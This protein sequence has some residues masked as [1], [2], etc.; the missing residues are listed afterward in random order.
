MK[1]FDLLN[2][3]CPAGAAALVV[4]FF[5]KLPPAVLIFSAAALLVAAT[6]LNAARRARMD[7]LHRRCDEL[8]N[9]LEQQ[10]D[11]HEQAISQLKSEQETARSAFFSEISHSLRM[12]ISVIQGYA[13]LMQSGAVDQVRV[14]EYL[15]R[16][17]HHTHRM[18]DVL[19]TKLSP[20]LEDGSVSPNQGQVDLVLLV[21]NQIKDL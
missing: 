6:V 12:P 15:D 20:P 1:Q 14:S 17:L 16:I 2:L 10:R 21:K 9:R 19:S 4:G 18:S 8:Y 11:A 13:E 3:L 5:L 7:E